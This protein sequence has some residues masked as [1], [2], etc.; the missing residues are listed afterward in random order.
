MDLVRLRSR[1]RGSC[2]IFAVVGLLVVIGTVQGAEWS[3]MKKCEDLGFC[4]RHR[5]RVV[6]PETTFSVVG[7]S[8][9]LCDREGVHMLCGRLR[10]GQSGETPVMFGISAL[11][12]GMYRLIIDDADPTLH[13]RY[14]VKDVITDEVQSLRLSESH[15]TLQVGR[16]EL[17]ALGA[18]HPY[19]VVTYNPFQID[20]MLGREFPVRIIS[21]NS[22]SLLRFETHRQ[23]PTPAPTPDPPTTAATVVSSEARD[24]LGSPTEIEDKAAPLDIGNID[25]SQEGGSDAHAE[26]VDETFDDNFGDPADEYQG[27]AVQS[28]SPHPETSSKNIED[29]GLWGESFQSH[30]DPKVRG[31]ESIGA[32][33]SF[34]FA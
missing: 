17:A 2:L 7:E 9:A 28:A 11:P 27:N 30:H 3:K 31:P 29:D 4:R 6:L 23:R 26:D 14:V 5:A 16:V 10:R 20:L 18:N 33:V 21:F 25:V 15:L 13:K 19:I 32:D 1:R 8:V 24:P 22:E 34:P 12:D